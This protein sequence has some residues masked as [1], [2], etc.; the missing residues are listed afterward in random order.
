MLRTSNCNRKQ[1]MM[2]LLVDTFEAGDLVYVLNF[3]A[4]EKWIPDE[5]IQSNGPVSFSIQLQNGKIV[6]RHRDHLQ[7]R[8]ERQQARSDLET[9]AVNDDSDMLTEMPSIETSAETSPEIA[10]TEG[11][12]SNN[13]H[14]ENSSNEA[15]TS[16]STS[17]T[18]AIPRYPQ[19]VRKEPDRFHPSF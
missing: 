17:L 15:A 1:H 12:S 13:R 3:R 6:R 16:T 5:I 8:T 19:R 7:Q 2:R 11:A 10:D 18:S 14:V 4:G 9:A